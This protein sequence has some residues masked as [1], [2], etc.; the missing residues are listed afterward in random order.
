MASKLFL[1]SLLLVPGVLSAVLAQP[2]GNTAARYEHKVPSL[3]KT[4]SMR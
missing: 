1:T 2:V 3:S 4:G